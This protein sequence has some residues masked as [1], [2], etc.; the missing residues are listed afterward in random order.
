[1]GFDLTALLIALAPVAGLAIGAVAGWLLPKLK[2]LVESTPTKIDD[3]AWNNLVKEFTAA[4][5]ID[6]EQLDKL[7]NMPTGGK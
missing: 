7:V 1:M 5:V 6:S 3:A 2:G 4:G